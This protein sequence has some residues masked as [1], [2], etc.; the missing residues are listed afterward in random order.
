MFFKLVIGL[1]LVVS[2]NF[3][4]V[5]ALYAEEEPAVIFAEILLVQDEQKDIIERPDI[6]IIVDGIKLE[7]KEVPVIFNGSSYFPLRFILSNLGVPNDDKHILWDDT[8]KSVVINTE[9]NNGNSVGKTNIQLKVGSHTVVINNSSLALATPPVIYKNKVYIPIRFISETMN[10]KVVWDEKTFSIVIC[11]ANQYESV[12]K[13]LDLA[14]G[15]FKTFKRYKIKIE[16]SAQSSA[17]IDFGGV[18]KIEIEVDNT[19]QIIHRTEKHYHHIDLI[20]QNE[21]FIINGCTYKKVNNKWE[22]EIIKDLKNDITFFPLFELN[23]TIYAGL[24]PVDTKNILTYSGDISLKNFPYSQDVSFK[25]SSNINIDKE[26][27]VI[28]GIGTSGSAMLPSRTTN[29]AGGAFLNF[30]EINGNF[31]IVCPEDL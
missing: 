21:Y 4:Q 29:Y 15:K 28:K 5:I 8:E 26:T 12:K 3:H 14:F 13:Q 6:K 19:K 1:I 11:D 7:N 25:C 24:K 18:T 20:Y 23:D 30:S 22:K 17:K 16:D 9:T 31:E 10:K 27:G 2:A